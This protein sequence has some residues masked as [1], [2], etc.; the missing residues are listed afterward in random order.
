MYFKLEFETMN[1][2]VEYEALVLGLWD[3]KGMKIEELLVFGDATFIVHHNR[4]IY[5]AKNPR[6]RKYRNEVW[7]II[8]I[9]F[10][11]FNTSFVPREEN[12]LAD[13]LVVFLVTLKFHYLLNSSMM[14]K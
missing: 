1:N 4:N 9:F 6:L 14:L 8:D 5:Q 2:I 10:L 12:A 13:S 7:D 3:A 11:D